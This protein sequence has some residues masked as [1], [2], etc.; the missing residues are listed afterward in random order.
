MEKLKLLLTSRKFWAALIGLVLIVVKAYRPDFPL[1]NDQL[2]AIVVVLVGYIMGTAIQD[3]QIAQSNVILYPKGQDQ[4]P[5]PKDQAT[6]Q[7]PAP[8]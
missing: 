5:P 7:P 1:Q 4:T 3:S 6:R 2:T 8:G